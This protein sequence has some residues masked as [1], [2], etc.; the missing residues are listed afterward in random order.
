M[1]IILYT[2]RDVGGLKTNR[3]KEKERKRDEKNKA[4]ND[5]EVA[6]S[7]M[8]GREKGGRELCINFVAFLKTR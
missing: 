1:S 5:H 4:E 6:V 2:D 8:K 7:V 3:K